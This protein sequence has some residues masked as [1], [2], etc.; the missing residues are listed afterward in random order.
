MGLVLEKSQE[1]NQLMGSISQK[2]VSQTN[3]SQNVTNLMQKIAQLS[4]N[5]SKSSEKV[6]RSIIETAQVAAQARVYR[7]SV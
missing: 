7:S 3:T 2:T 4:D 1:I 5:T 6:A